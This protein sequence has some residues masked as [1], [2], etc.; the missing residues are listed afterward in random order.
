MPNSLGEKNANRNFS[1]TE[2]E[3]IALSTLIRELIPFM[4]PM[5]ETVGLF[6]ILTR[7]PVFFCTV[8][9]DNEICITVEKIPKFTSRTKH[10]AINYHHF[11]CFV[12]DGTIIVN[13]ID[14]TELLR[15]LVSTGP[16]MPSIQWMQTERHRSYSVKIYLD[17]I[18]NLGN[19]ES[20]FP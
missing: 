15:Q 3:R 12:S 18:Y 20:I 13:S 5:K 1:T 9:E 14:T 7:Y 4:S 6:R 2:S 11:R 10:I 16:A 17:E 8:W 19:Y